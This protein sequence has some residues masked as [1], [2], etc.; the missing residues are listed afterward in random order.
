MHTLEGTHENE[1][2]ETVFNQAVDHVFHFC[3]E[4]GRLPR[5]ILVHR[6]V[7]PYLLSTQT[8]GAYPCNLGGRGVSPA[9]TFMGV[10]IRAINLPSVFTVVS[11]L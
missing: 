9:N 7:L 2:R 3:L 5:E 1:P 11:P 10:S 4:H 6:T 8:G